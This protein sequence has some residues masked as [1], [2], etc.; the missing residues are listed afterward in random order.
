MTTSDLDLRSFPQYHVV[1]QCYMV[2]QVAKVCFHM[3]E[4]VKLVA[5]MKE[6]HSH[7]KNRQG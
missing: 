5:P 1:M 6:V 7:R 4:R 2:V 3:R